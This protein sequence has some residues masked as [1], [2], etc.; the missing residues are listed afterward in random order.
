MSS[1][2]P[3]R[4]Y[5]WRVEAATDSRSS[6]S[7]DVTTAVSGVGMVPGAIA[8]QRTPIGASSAATDFVSPTTA[9]FA[10]V[11][12]CGPS[13]PITPAMLDVEMIE[14]EPCA[15]ITRDACLHP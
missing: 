15:T 4:P 7:P 11:Y 12:A 2:L 3:A 10:A 5:R 14:P 9:V 6:G 1:A 13:P 8:L